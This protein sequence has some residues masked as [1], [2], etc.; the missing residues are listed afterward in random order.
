[1]VN[2]L[3]VSRSFHIISNAASCCRRGNILL[4]CLLRSHCC[5][6]LIVLA[7]L[8]VHVMQQPQVQVQ[9]NRHVYQHQRYILIPLNFQ[10]SIRQVTSSQ[11]LFTNNNYPQRC[12]TRRMF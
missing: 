11:L 7:P 3:V 4:H 1:M 9:C 10:N 12:S 5:H 2:Q 6:I 8:G